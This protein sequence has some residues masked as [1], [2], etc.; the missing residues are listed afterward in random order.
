MLT[1]IHM[2][3]CMHGADAD[4]V[5]QARAT[6]STQEKKRETNPSR[7]PQECSGDTG[8]LVT[9]RIAEPLKEESLWIFY[10]PLQ[11]TPCICQ[12]VLG[13]SSVNLA[14][15]RR[16]ATF[17]T[18]TSAL[19]Q[20]RPC[21]SCW[22]VCP[23]CTLP[24]KGT[25]VSARA[26]SPGAACVPPACCRGGAGGTPEQGQQQEPSSAGADTP[27]FVPPG[28]FGEVNAERSGLLLGMFLRLSSGDPPL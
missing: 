15:V 6:K 20:H 4:T 12:R 17:L 9:N 14:H 21:P 23:L 8:Q 22:S 19:H 24:R 5:P 27:R 7:R 18:S 3:R 26:L 25:R 11:S 1:H 2:C 28:I 10:L 13:A 16:L